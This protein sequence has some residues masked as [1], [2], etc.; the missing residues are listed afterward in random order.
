ME[1]DDSMD[2]IYRSAYERILYA[3]YVRRQSWDGKK[4]RATLD[5]TLSWLVPAQERSSSL[6]FLQFE[7]LR[8]RD[9]A[10]IDFIKDHLGVSD[11]AA[12][13]AALD[14]RYRPLIAGHL[15]YARRQGRMIME[16]NA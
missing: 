6:P 14:A 9:A 1:T 4:F 16:E 2:A 5:D 11:D 13:F 10:F 7:F 8:G 3:E 12:A 15:E